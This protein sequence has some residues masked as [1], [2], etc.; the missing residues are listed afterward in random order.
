MFFLVFL[1]SLLRLETFAGIE[2]CSAPEEKTSWQQAIWP[3]WP[4]LE[5]RIGDVIDVKLFLKEGVELIVF[6]ASLPII[7]KELMRVDRYNR[8]DFPALNDNKIRKFFKSS[9]EHT[10]KLLDSTDLFL[11]LHLDQTKQ[12]K[13]KSKNKLVRRIAR[14]NQLYLGITIQII[15]YLI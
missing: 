14:S 8:F 15:L 10:N 5:V 1:K 7:D 3:F 4:S 13:I 2:F 11:F 6:P 12:I 9:T